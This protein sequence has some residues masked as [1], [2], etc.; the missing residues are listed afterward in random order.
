LHCRG[1]AVRIAGIEPERRIQQ[2]R[3]GRQQALGRE[4]EI[5]REPSLAHEEA[6][7]FLGGGDVGAVIEDH[8][9]EEIAYNGESLAIR[10]ERPFD[11]GAVLVVILWPLVFQR[12]DD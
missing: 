1:H 2:L 9:T 5:V 7:E 3:H 4:I 6:D 11:G 8:G 12:V 10:A